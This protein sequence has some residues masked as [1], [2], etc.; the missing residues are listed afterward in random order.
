[1]SVAGA[2]SHQVASKFIITHGRQHQPVSACEQYAL[3]GSLQRRSVQRLPRRAR[4]GIDLI[5]EHAENGQM[6]L[7]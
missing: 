5:K 3:F 4:K 6:R 2:Q 1:L 7:L